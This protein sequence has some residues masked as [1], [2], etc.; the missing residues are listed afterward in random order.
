MKKHCNCN[1]NRECCRLDTNTTKT[2]QL[3]DINTEMNEMLEFSDKDF[4]AAI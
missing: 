3:T 4:K 2:K 1:K